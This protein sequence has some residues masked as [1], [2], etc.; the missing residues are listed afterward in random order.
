[1]SLLSFHRLIWL[2][3]PKSLI[4]PFPFCTMKSS[5]VN[6]V[7]KLLSWSEWYFLVL[8]FYTACAWGWLTTFR[9]SPLVLF[10]HVKWNKYIQPTSSTRRLKTEILR[11]QFVTCGILPLFTTL[12]LICLNIYVTLIIYSWTLFLKCLWII[13][14]VLMKVFF[15]VYKFMPSVGLDRLCKYWLSVTL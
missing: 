4:G 3:T 12:P 7:F 13:L 14:F 15:L 5:T 2:T 11:F 9:N 10:S 6:N 8:G 1:M